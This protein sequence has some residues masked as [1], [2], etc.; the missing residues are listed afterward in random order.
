MPHGITIDNHGNI[1][2]TDVGLHQVLKFPPGFGN[3]TPLLTLG[4]KYSYLY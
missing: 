3:G 4:T 1:W 2:V